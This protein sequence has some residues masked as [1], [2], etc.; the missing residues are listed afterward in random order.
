MSSSLKQKKLCPSLLQCDLFKELRSSDPRRCL[1][2]SRS[3]SC[4]WFGTSEAIVLWPQCCPGRTSPLTSWLLDRDLPSAGNPSSV[5][6]SVRLTLGSLKTQK[7]RRELWMYAAEYTIWSGVLFSFKTCSVV[8][9]LPQ[10]LELG[11]S[12]TTMV[13]LKVLYFKNNIMF[14]PRLACPSLSF[15]GQ[16]DFCAFEG[17]R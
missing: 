2:V 4:S 16:S 12:F 13:S 7:E 10:H 3:G 11:L 5:F 9:Q 8:A 17:C 14:C 1:W 15:Y 6:W